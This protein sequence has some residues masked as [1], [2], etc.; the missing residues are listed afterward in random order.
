MKREDLSI[1]FI[2]GLPRIQM[3]IYFNLLVVDHLSKME[4][5]R[6]FKNIVYAIHVVFYYLRRLWG[7][8]VYPKPLL[9]SD[10]TNSL[11]ISRGNFGR[12]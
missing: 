9:Q 1:D 8:M 2:L 7:Y 11:D 10:T 3:G 6:P 12:D 4:N 5:S